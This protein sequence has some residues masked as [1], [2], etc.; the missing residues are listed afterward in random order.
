MIIEGANITPEIIAAIK[1]FQCGR[2]DWMIERL[3]AINDLLLDHHDDD[4]YEPKEILSAMSEVRLIKRYINDF[5]EG[6]QHE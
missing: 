1:D 5:I 6:G 3:D 4:Y 2:N